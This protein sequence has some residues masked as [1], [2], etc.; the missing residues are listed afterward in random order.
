VR[1]LWHGVG[2]EANLLPNGWKWKIEDTQEKENQE[3]KGVPAAGGG[4][5]WER[6][7][8]DYSKK[9]GYDGTVRKTENMEPG[10]CCPKIP[11]KE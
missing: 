7:Q 10:C 3:E 9:K 8:G 1:A 2:A 11:R 6:G 5:F 4:V